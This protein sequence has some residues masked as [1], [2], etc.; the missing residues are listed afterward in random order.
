MHF[1]NLENHMVVEQSPTCMSPKTRRD[2]E[3]QYGTPEEQR[4]ES[5][6]DIDKRVEQMSAFDCI[7]H[8]EVVALIEGMP[9]ELTRQITE[10]WRSQVRA[11]EI[12]EL[13]DEA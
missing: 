12:S 9:E 8:M 10:N 3:Y 1:P 11:W 7:D 6:K 5:I 2:W 4:A 13:E